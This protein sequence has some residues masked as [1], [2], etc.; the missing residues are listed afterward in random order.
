MKVLN[1]YRD[2][3]ALWEEATRDTKDKVIITLD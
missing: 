3:L 2:G 1:L